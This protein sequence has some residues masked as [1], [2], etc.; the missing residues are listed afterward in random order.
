MKPP[1]TLTAIGIPGLPEFTTG[2]DIAAIVTPYAA[3]LRWPDG[4]VGVAAGDVIVVT[5]KIVSK[6]EGRQ[7]AARSRDALIEAEAAAVVASRAHAGGTTQIVRT[8]HG[9][10]LAAAGVDMSNTPAGTALLLPVDP[11]SSAALLRTRFQQLLGVAD[12]GVLITDSAGRPW[13]EGVTDIAIGIA[14]VHPLVDLR[15]NLD[16]HGRVLDATVVAIADEI[17]GASELVRPK[18]GAVPVAIVRGVGQTSAEAAPARVL[19]RPP[20]HDLFSLGTAEA[21]RLGAQQAV[22]SRRTIRQFRGDPVPADV[23]EQAIDTALT[24]PSPHHSTPVRF[25]LTQPDTR[26]GLLD[27]M[28]AQ[29]RADLRDLDGFDDAAIDQ[30]LQRG[31]VLREAPEVVWVFSD[32]ESALHD[33]P[34]VRRRTAE[35]D[36]FMLAG[37]AAVQSLLIALAAQGVG[38]AWLSAPLFCPQ[39]VTTTLRLPRA[40]QPLGAVAAGYPHSPPPARQSRPCSENI[41]R[42]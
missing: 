5:S 31:S 10:V 41:V 26:Q 16:A 4:T 38:T 15:G 33:Y 42:R 39:V 9:F 24:A 21:L 13:R 3:S 36:L 35:R 19:V 17:A 27:A 12:L 2:D 32:L 28:A 40:W 29:W 1:L 7:V 25:V 34:D 6:V 14:G 8:R 22:T 20:E 23:L 11:D 30:H 18:A 37:G